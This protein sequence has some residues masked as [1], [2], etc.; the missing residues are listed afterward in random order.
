MRLK[1]GKILCHKWLVIYNIELDV[2]YLIYIIDY[3]KLSVMCFLQTDEYDWLANR[4][5]YMTTSDLL[6]TNKNIYIGEL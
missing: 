3:N 6:D 5:E 2:I 4:A 1:F